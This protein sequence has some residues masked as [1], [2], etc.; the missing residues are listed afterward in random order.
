[1]D[2]KVAVKNLTVSRKVLVAAIFLVSFLSIHVPDIL[3]TL[4]DALFLFLFIGNWRKKADLLPNKFLKQVWNLAVF[5]FF[6]GFLISSFNSDFIRFITLIIQ[7]LFCFLV[8]SSVITNLVK[9]DIDYLFLL[10]KSYVA[11]IATVSLIG[12]ILYFFFPD[13]SINYSTSALRRMGSLM[14][15]PNQLASNIATAFLFL[16]FL[17]ERKK[18]N[19]AFK[20]FCM[21]CLLL[22][23]ALTSSFGGI[24][25]LLSGT[26]VFFIIGKNRA[27]VLNLIV[28]G[29]VSI[30]VFS[31]FIPLPEVFSERVINN[32]KATD[33]ADLG[34]Y[35]ARVKLA[36]K[37]WDFISAN[38]ITG[39]GADNF[40]EASHMHNDVH[41]GYILIWVEGGIL[42]IFGL[43]LIT[44]IFPLYAFL[45][46][47]ADFKKDKLNLYSVSF[48][49]TLLFILNISSHTQ[50]Y[51]R[52]WFVPF[53]LLLNYITISK[54]LKNGKA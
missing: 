47:S 21:F 40:I 3:F 8:L 53:F 23:M 15:N 31:F 30:I 46:G 13:I 32:L 12:I 18:V 27:V 5:L 16:L 19:L 24:L 6:L 39:V 54:N 42:S 38:P 11:G 9:N 35:E 44:L 25:A 43:I 28:V 22:G 37:A 51:G 2:I 49:F 1:M 7:Y 29:I 41:N 14:Y 45:F 20:A 4:S 48:A 33:V 26:I 34:S 10:I 36:E 17:I 50:F 52:Y